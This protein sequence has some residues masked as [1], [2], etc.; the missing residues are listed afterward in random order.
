MNTEVV[1]INTTL[2]KDLLRE[3]DSYAEE[4]QE[5]RSTAIRQL[6]FAA[7]KEISKNKI[8][9]DY[10]NNKITLRQVA[11][12][13]GVAYWEAMDILVE[14]GVPVQN[15]TKEEIQNRKQKIERD[16]F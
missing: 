6:L 7:L 2:T 15:L 13:L 5:D 8:I 10:K 4:H 12:K 14:A 1:R 11:E 16:T 9:N 3:L